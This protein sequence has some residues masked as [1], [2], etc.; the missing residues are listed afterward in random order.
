[1]SALTPHPAHLTVQIF[2]VRK[3]VVSESEVL[4][5]NENI[6]DLDGFYVH[7]LMQNHTQTEVWHSGRH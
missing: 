7:T 3:P 1:M 5:H 4:A 6:G 2:A